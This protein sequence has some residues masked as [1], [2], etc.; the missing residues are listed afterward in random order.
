MTET[1]IHIGDGEVSGG[2]AFGSGAQATGKGGRIVNKH[3]I[4]Y[5]TDAPILLPATATSPTVAHRGMGFIAK[6]IQ[7]ITEGTIG[8]LLANLISLHR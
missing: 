4:R 6:A 1:R 3:A 7:S 8:S 5:S 2:F